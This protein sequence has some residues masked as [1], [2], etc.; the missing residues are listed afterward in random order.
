MK[1]IIKGGAVL[2]VAS[3]LVFGASGIAGA[4]ST[5]PKQQSSA[6]YVKTVCGVYNSLIADVNSYETSLGTLDQGDPTSFVPA[7]T[8]QTNTLLSTVQG[9]ETAL[10]GAYPNISNGKKVGALL[11]TNATEIDSALT[12]ALGQLQAGGVVLQVCPLFGAQIDWLPDG[13]LR[14]SDSSMSI[15]CRDEPSQNNCPRVFSC[16]AMP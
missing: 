2:V 14:H 4:A 13:A 10:K 3:G 8:T 11:A 6:K 5:K 1:G 7:A 15:I 16:Q 12:T 9:A